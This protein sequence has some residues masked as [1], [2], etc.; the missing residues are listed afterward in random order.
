MKETE[1]LHQ[2]RVERFQEGILKK[3]D[4]PAFE[5]RAMRIVGNIRLVSYLP[6]LFSFL[7][8]LYAAYYFASLYSGHKMAAMIV[9]SVTI[10]ALWEL[11][12]RFVGMQMVEGFINE[13]EKGKRWWLP[14]MVCL[15]IGSFAVSYWGGDRFVN[16]ESSPP[17]EWV[18]PALSS[19]LAEVDRIQS[20]INSQEK[21]T[22]KGRITRDANRNLKG[23][24]A[25]KA[26]AQEKVNAIQAGMKEK[27]TATLS[28]FEQ[29]TVSLGIAFG[30]LAGMM[31]FLLIGLFFW[32][33]KI[34]DTVYRLLKRKGMSHKQAQSQ[35]NSSSWNP[36]QVGSAVSSN[37]VE[38]K[39]FSFSSSANDVPA[40]RFPVAENQPVKTMQTQ[41]VTEPK[42]ENENVKTDRV[43][44]AIPFEITNIP[45]QD[46]VSEVEIEGEVFRVHRF[47]NSKGVSEK[48]VEYIKT[49]GEMRLLDRRAVSQYLNSYKSKPDTENNIAK[50]EYFRKMKEAVCA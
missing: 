43:K 48:K 39:G 50:R 19:A 42:R 17:A 7:A 4:K 40:S 34:E 14:I 44:N 12:K 27:N 13:Q 25:Q 8:A 3:R 9:V 26:A 31:D 21:T 33:E 23:L 5:V 2:E 10:L 46:S 38:V 36:Y 32:A 45:A 6:N 24:Y 18:D 49:D 30:L 28:A 29:K 15:V 35:L 20:S 47:T 16:E 1:I 37:Q 22:W 11:A 41:L